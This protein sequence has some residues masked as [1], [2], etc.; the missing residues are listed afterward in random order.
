MDQV[1]EKVQQAVKDYAGGEWFKAR[2]YAL[3]DTE[4]QQYSVILIP[5]EDYPFDVKTRVELF[6]RVVGDFIVVEK[7]MSDKPLWKDLVAMGV[8]RQQIILS[9]IGEQLPQET[10]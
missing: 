3:I 7:D 5:D 9:Y 6:V 10:V 1:A 8:P 2:V 4:Q